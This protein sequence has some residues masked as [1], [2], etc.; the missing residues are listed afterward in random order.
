MPELPEVETTRLG[1]APHIQGRRL[2]RVLVRQPRLRWPI[3]VFIGLVLARNNSTTQEELSAKNALVNHAGELFPDLLSVNRVPSKYASTEDRLVVRLKDISPSLGQGSLKIAG[4]AAYRAGV[5][6]SLKRIAG[7]EVGQAL[8]EA[9]GKGENVT[10]RPAVVADVVRRDGHGSFFY[11]NSGC[12]VTATFD[13]DNDIVGNPSESVLKAEPWR[14]REPSIGLFHELVH[15]YVSQVHKSKEKFSA[16][17]KSIQVSDSGFKGEVRAAGIPYRENGVTYPFDDPSF[18]PISE[19]AYRREL[20]RAD[21][22]ET[23]LQRTR[24]GDGNEATD[25]RAGQIPL[26]ESKRPVD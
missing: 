8:L 3:P 7:T 20:A 11:E 23:Y 24:Y 1:I 22:D 15:V 12:G 4:N 25:G 9:V 19:N 2:R 16:G 21:K 17:G 13:P 10:I 5:E 14:R 6:K 26:E 18:N